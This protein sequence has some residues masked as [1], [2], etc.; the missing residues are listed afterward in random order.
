MAPS[1][2]D[3]PSGGCLPPGPVLAAVDHA[4]APAAAVE[5]GVVAV[6]GARVPAVVAGPARSSEPDP[7]QVARVSIVRTS[8]P[9]TSRADRRAIAQSD[10]V[11]GVPRRS[12]PSHSERPG[13][14]TPAGSGAGP[15]VEDVQPL[16]DRLG[17]AFGDAGGDQDLGDGRADPLLPVALP[18]LPGFPHVEVARSPSRLTTRWTTWPLGGSSPISALIRW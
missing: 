16:L 1:F 9:G 15:D 8:R 7:S 5:A 3:G 14:N 12:C 6:V 18:I 10:H 17:W 11:F 2:A 4:A 13:A